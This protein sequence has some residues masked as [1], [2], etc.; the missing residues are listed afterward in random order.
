MEKKESPNLQASAG[1]GSSKIAALTGKFFSITKFTLGIC[2]LAV[3]Y[4]VSVSLVNEV[5]VIN[6]KLQVYFW[7][8]ALSFM[9]IYLFAWE[10]A[11]IYVKGQKVVEIVF[12]F[13][14]PLVKVAPFLLPIYTILLFALYGILCFFYKPA[15]IIS[16]FVFFFGFSISLHLV[17]SAKSMRSRQGDLLKANYIFGFSLIYIID[18]ALLA[19]GL[20]LVF[21]EFSCV[22]F[23]N[24]SFQISG[25]IFYAVFKQ[26]F[27]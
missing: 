5:A 6:D 16:W 9:F 8:G 19:F 11:I 4:A 25:S 14:K 13:F 24:S 2:L 15:D 21:K 18:L 27:L 10:P 22:R 17:F 23:F 7:S 12:S 26:L 1:G 3:V 20:N